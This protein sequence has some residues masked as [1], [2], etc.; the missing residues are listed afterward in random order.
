[1]PKHR[2]RRATP[3]G[4]KYGPPDGVA[5]LRVAQPRVCAALLAGGRLRA[6]TVIGSCGS[7]P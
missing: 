6:I 1:M 7:G 5:C 3:P 2:N 4:A